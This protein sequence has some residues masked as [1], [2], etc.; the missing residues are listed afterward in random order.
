MP[1]QSL[2]VFPTQTAKEFIGAVIAGN[3]A[4]AVA[5]GR[6]AP[7][8]LDTRGAAGETAILI[9][10]QRGDVAMVEALLSAGAN[11]NGGPDR[12]PLHPATRAEDTRMLDMLL[13]AGANPNVSFDGQS[14]LMQAALIGAMPH[15]QHLI[16]SGA[17][18]EL[19]DTIGETPA[20]TAAG[21]DQ[22]EMVWYLL[23]HGATVWTIPKS[24][25]SIAVFANSSRVRRDTPKGKALASVI[26][27]IK[28]EGFP[29]PP[30]PPP[31]LRKLMSEGNW[32]P[33]RGG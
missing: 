25:F 9:A 7:D 28:A 16:A 14:P 15:A 31:E 1:D 30:P 26:E 23:N 3:P 13:K 29:W 27:L 24:G 22:W 5:A 10:V 21:A 33:R 19:G 6:K 2:D 20:I 12:T 18:A 11:A 4:M 32:P 8:G 17:R